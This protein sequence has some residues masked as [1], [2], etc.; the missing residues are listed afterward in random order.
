M[1]SMIVLNPTMI[2][3]SFHDCIKSYHDCA[4]TLLSAR[5]ARLK[6]FAVAILLGLPLVSLRVMARPEQVANLMVQRPLVQAVRAVGHNGEGAARDAA[7]VVG[8]AADAHLPAGHQ[9]THIS[10]SQQTLWTEDKETA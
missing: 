8:F 4:K 3:K 6:Q 2:V 1:P 7:N 10:W 9:H 5:L